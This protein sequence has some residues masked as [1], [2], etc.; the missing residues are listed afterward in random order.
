MIISRSLV[1]KPAFAVLWRAYLGFGALLLTLYFL[2]P[3]FKGSGVLFNFIGLSSALVILAGIRI[4]KPAA[5]TAWYL[6]VAGQLFFVMGDAFY[7]GYNALFHK[8]VPFP[9]PADFLYLAV[10]PALVAGLL[11]IIKRRS[12]RGDR[13]SLIDALILTTGLALLSWVFLMAPYAEDPTLRLIEKLVSIAYPL[14]DV[15]LLAV[16]IRLAVGGDSRKPALGLLIMS[17]VALLTTDSIL[18]LLTLN[19]GYEEGGLLDAGWAI[20]YLLWGAAALHPSMR[21]LEEP[22]PRREGRI[23]R[24]RLVL[25]T[26]ASL[27]APAVQA[28]ETARGN[29]VDPP[30]M[31]AASVSLFCLVVA[32]M[33]GLLRESER[34]AA[35]ERALRE[36]ARALVSAGSRNEVYRAAI[37]S[38]V[39]LTGPGHHARMAVLA[40]TGELRA[41]GSEA[42]GAE[43]QLRAQDLTTLDA[44]ALRQRRA[45]EVDLRSGKL[46]TDLKLPHDVTT[47]TIFPL[48]VSQELRGLIFVAGPR[49]FSDQITDAM[50]TLA[51]QIAL[52]LES[53]VLTEDLLISKSE[54]RFRSLVQ[55]SS[56]LITVI[57]GDS[58]IK[59]QSPSAERV[60]GY[61]PGELVGRKFAE[62]LHPHERGRVVALL[63]DSITSAHPQVEVVE[64]RLRHANGSWLLFEIF[65]TNLL[66]D[67][68]VQGIVLNGRDISERKEFEQQLR[69]QA[70][71]D[72]VTDLA[73]RA[74]FT[75]RVEH[76][77]SR[78]TREE[79]GLGVI[80]VDLD[81]FKMI[82]DSLGH[83]AGDEVL[84]QVG[85]RLLQCVRPMDTVARFG[86]DEFA[87]LLEDTRTPEAVAEI[88]DRILGAF[89]APIRLDDKD[90][91]IRAS[92]GIATI[93][94]EEAMTSAADELIRNADVAMYMAKREGKGQYRIFEQHMHSNVLARLETKGALQRALER[95][96]LT[97]HYQPVIELPTKRV[98]GFEALVRWQHPER[99]LVSPAEFIPLAEE[100]GLIV[101]IGNRVLQEACTQAVFLQEMAPVDPPLT[102]SVNIS[103]RQ[104]QQP[105]FTDQIKSILEETRLNPS[106]LMLEITESLLMIDTDAM[107]EKLHELKEIGVQLAVDDF[108]TGYSSLSYLSRFPV[109]ALKIDRSFVNKVEL[110]GQE[111]DLA[112]AIVK[113]GETLKLKTIAEGIELPEQLDLFVGLGCNLGQ[114]FLM[115]KPMAIDDAL[116]FLH[117]PLAE[118]SAPG[119]SI[120]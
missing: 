42:T 46:R 6:F 117:L 109:D 20:Y 57:E 19:G 63:A 47:M 68:N 5:R 12:P 75:N 105:D 43:W 11:I 99:G 2:V 67:P 48:F 119:P 23:S 92:I 10:Y 79:S 45:L 87:V 58:T 115:A 118:E 16:A 103:V 80:F 95:G 73:N 89:D 38:M 111:S 86:G 94:A 54:A 70:F 114:G 62:L 101:P 60:L 29:P 61:D 25:L 77:L 112:A 72:P 59:Y 37:K 9:S 110:G 51:V 65:R 83:A 34:S 28:V 93:D 56:D 106:C 15:C 96:E 90:V 108:G 113:L 17:A 64:C 107:V 52:A 100:T 66:D 24:A 116:D 1:A 21:S 69:H 53:A 78:Q 30:I 98:I 91:Y 76:T 82:N 71:H 41:C 27:I 88:A 104:L 39:T 18:G 26:A 81:D 7:Y 4:H 8:D 44:V 40:P 32:R 33:V 55:N 50:Q 22:V 85:K 36:A 84:M 49:A 31:V 97:C 14:M 13:P 102:M 3:P 74:L 35:R 120:G